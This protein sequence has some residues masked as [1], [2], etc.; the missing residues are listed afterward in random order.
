MSEQHRLFLR[1]MIGKPELEIA[2]QIFAGMGFAVRR[3]AMV[4]QVQGVDMRALLQLTPH[5]EPVAGR[6][7]QTMQNHKRHAGTTQIF[8][9]QF[10]R[11][12]AGAVLVV[13][14]G[15]NQNCAFCGSALL[16][17]AIIA[18]IK[19]AAIFRLAPGYCAVRNFRWSPLS[20]GASKQAA[21]PGSGRLAICGPTEVPHKTIQGRARS[22]GEIRYI[23]G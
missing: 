18:R 16:Q 4:A 20:H 14:L 17:A 21:P 23:L 11:S 2:P 13:N 12:H 15:G 3:L 10:Q 5:T 22:P 19:C 9:V 8:V 6:T 7:K 1:Q